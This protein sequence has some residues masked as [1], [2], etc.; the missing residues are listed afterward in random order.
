MINELL[1]LFPRSIK[2]RVK[3]R[4]AVPDMEWSMG[5]LARLGFRPR[6]SL[7][8]GAYKGEWT[9]LCLKIFP[10]TRVLMIEVQPH[11]I[12]ALRD[13][14][15]R[16]H[17]SIEVCEAL[18]GAREAPDVTYY[19]ADTGTS[20]L[21]EAQ[22]SVPAVQAKARLRTL[23]G[24]VRDLGWPSV[25]F[26]KIDVQGYELEVLRGAS[27]TLRTSEVVLMEC[28][29]IPI[30]EGAPLLAETIRFMD[31]HGFRVY[32]ICSCIRRPRDRA[33]WQSDLIF[34]RHG[35]KLVSSS[36]WA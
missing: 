2:D 35:S 29:L 26:L 23:D 36:E 16:S 21:R 1:R 19:L 14:A 28:N 7:D 18:L 15:A 6:C 34:V 5:N 30:Y 12:V 11:L 8:L 32:D 20:A 27:D 31:D 10:T 3:R 25:D 22:P 24:V 17:G 13:K 9:D 4:L 33:L